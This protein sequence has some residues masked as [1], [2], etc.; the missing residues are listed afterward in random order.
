MA[1]LLPVK[2]KR[3]IDFLKEK[4]G[5]SGPY[6]VDKHQFMVKDQLRLRLPD[7]ADD[8]MIGVEILQRI[9]PIAGV[10]LD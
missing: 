8:E 4:Q 2:P 3:L 5:F 1:R 10:R 9:L 6:R 7:I